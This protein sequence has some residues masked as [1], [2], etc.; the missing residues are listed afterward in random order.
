M[1]FLIILKSIL[2][3]KRNL[4]WIYSSRIFIE[5]QKCR[6]WKARTR[7][8]ITPLLIGCTTLLLK[9][10]IRLSKQSLPSCNSPVVSPAPSPR[11]PRC[12]A[13]QLLLMFCRLQEQ[14]S[15]ALGWQRSS[16]CVQP[17]QQLWGGEAAPCSPCAGC[18]LALIAGSCGCGFGILA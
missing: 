13:W 1:L 11:L 6:G 17:Q 8:S 5:S 2:L 15:S 12:P 3:Q 16:W 18:S 10:C 14:Q 7:S 9:K 4:L